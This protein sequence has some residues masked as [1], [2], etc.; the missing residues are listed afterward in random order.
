[1]KAFARIT[2][3]ALL[4]GGLLVF[5]LGA[6]AGT[7]SKLPAA[8]RYYPLVGHWKGK[9]HLSEAG[10]API[11]LALRLTCN[12]AASGWAVRCAMVAKNDKMTMTESDLM[13]VD[14]ITGKGH[15]YAVTNQGETHD[16][17]AE[18][19]DRKTMKAHYAWSADGKQMVEN[20]T[21]MLAR[22]KSMEFH[23][24]VTADGKE[25]S[26]FSGKLAR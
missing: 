10:Q 16:H 8:A 17:I 25:V 2:A 1:M 5:T 23:S 9:G 14:A 22:G 4:A 13:G 19:V 6:T 21:L 18:W 12:K 26:A 15:W 24:V 11:A 3:V 7:T 20:I